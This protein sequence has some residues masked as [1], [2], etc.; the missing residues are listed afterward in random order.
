MDVL[1]LPG[2]MSGLSENAWALLGGS[3]E[4]AGVSLAPLENLLGKKVL[5]RP[6]GDNPSHCE[7]ASW[8]SAALGLGVGA[9]QKHSMV[10]LCFPSENFPVISHSPLRR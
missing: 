3:Q 10:H 9:G 8:E 2:H 4:W 1:K 5:V 6:P 7:L